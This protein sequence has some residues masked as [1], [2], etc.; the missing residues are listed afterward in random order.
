MLPL[1]AGASSRFG[2]VLQLVLINP[3]RRAP[4]AR[5]VP[6]PARRSPSILVNGLLIV[7]GPGRAQRADVD[8]ATRESFEL[9]PLLIDKPRVYAAA[10]SAVAVTA[11]AVCVL[12]L[13]AASARRSA[14][15]PT[16]RSARVVVGLNVKQLYAL[17]FGLGAACVAAAGVHRCA[18]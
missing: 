5:A 7:F 4:R 2:Y 8:Y 11:A 10:A 1:R 15:A 14:P 13:R 9:G 16:I 12:P 3:L 6:A 18:G 17:T